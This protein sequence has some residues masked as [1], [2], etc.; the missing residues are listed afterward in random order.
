MEEKK[1]MHSSGTYPKRV[2]VVEDDQDHAFLI[3]KT[4]ERWA[5]GKDCAFEIVDS[6]ERALE[7][8]DAASF[9]LILSDYHLPGK[10]GFE[11]LSEVQKRSLSVPLILMTAV[12]DEGLATKAL[13]A[14]FFDYITKSD[15]YIRML[16]NAIMDAYQRHLL[17]EEERKRGEDLV[18]KNAELNVKNEH[19]AEL[20]VSDDLTGLYNHRFLHE[21]FAEEFARCSRYHYPLSCLMIDI[22][23]FKSINDSYGHQAGDRVLK[24][25]ADFLSSYLRRADTVARYGGEE[26]VILLPHA[27]YE[28]AATLA[29]R[30]RKKVMDITFAQSL[31]LQIRITVSI[32]ISS[33]PDDPIDQKDTMLFYADKALYRA[34]TGGRNRVCL[35]QAVTKEYANA[36]LDVKIKDDQM[37]E[38]RQ[39]L[40]DISEMA[41]RAY[42]EATKALISA[43]EVKDQQTLG[44]AARVSYLSADIARE[45]GFNLEDIRIVEH[46]GLLHDI[47]KIC[48]KETIL[49]K[50]TGFTDEEYTKMKIHSVLGFQIVKPI[51]FLSEEASI[52]LHH[53]ERYDG[54]GYP[55]H[56]KG[57]EIPIGSRIVA[58]ADAFDTMRVACSR[59]K[60]TLSV[61]EAIK[62]LVDC[63]GTQ[64]DPEVV[65]ALIQALVKKG[66]LTG[67]TFDRSKLDDALKHAA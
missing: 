35:Y 8:F 9:D 43:L 1:E 40:I 45:M 63:S 19:L 41:K 29:E 5:N 49:L 27:G 46:G 12:G 31:H 34:K 64:F 25:L 4:L 26:F 65:H 56:L 57:K 66:D 14:G 3:E 10:T 58:V 11:L 28:G 23:H 17:R 54:S 62:E 48:V 15:D 18:Q 24:E 51:K 32:G 42:I 61:P 55:H 30:L 44:H 59:Y 38:L 60:T 36:A 7:R 53:H 13:K 67:G 6:V 33:Y 20:S 21:K 39:R 47:G 37:L 16:P 2:L 52:I 22:D 50:P